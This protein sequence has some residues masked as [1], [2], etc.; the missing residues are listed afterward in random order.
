MKRTRSRNAPN[1]I[2][3]NFHSRNP[4][5]NPR[6]APHL[7]PTHILP[8]KWMDLPC[9]RSFSPFNA[10]L[11]SARSQIVKLLSIENGIFIECFHRSKSYW[12]IRAGRWQLD[13]ITWISIPM[14]THHLC[15]V[16]MQPLLHASNASGKCFCSD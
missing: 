15:S 10:I 1:C 4:L 13:G 5:N 9:C 3:V 8:N 12:Y 6:N 14:Q 2:V 16:A 11:P 7:V